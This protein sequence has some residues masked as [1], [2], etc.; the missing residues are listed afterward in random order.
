MLLQVVGPRMIGQLYFK[1]F[2]V[3]EYSDFNFE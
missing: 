2:V 3:K 1:N